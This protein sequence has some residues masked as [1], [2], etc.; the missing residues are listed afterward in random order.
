MQPRLPKLD[1][2]PRLEQRVPGGSSRDLRLEGNFPLPQT[3]LEE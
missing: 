3:T 2:N 1:P